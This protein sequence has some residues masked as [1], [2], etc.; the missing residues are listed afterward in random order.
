M[1]GKIIRVI[2]TVCRTCL[3]IYTLLSFS[4]CIRDGSEECP[5]VDQSLKVSFT[6][7]KDT[8]VYSGIH[9]NEI[10]KATLYIYDEA[11]NYITEWS[12]DN[13]VFNKEYE[14]G[15]TLDPGIYN[16]VVWFNPEAPYQI[17]SVTIPPEEEGKTCRSESKVMLI[18]PGDGYIRDI[19]PP[20]LYG[21][22]LNTE[23]KATADN[24]LI[25]PM[26]LNNNIIN[27]TVNGLPMNDHTY[28]FIISDN[29]GC[30]N[31]DNDFVTYDYFNYVA[32]MQF[33]AFTKTVTSDT[34]NTSL[35]VL[36]LARG[37][38]VQIKLW[39]QTTDQQLYP[40]YDGQTDN[41]I[42]LILKANPDNDFEQTN[43]YDITLDFNS[44]MTV[45][46]TINGWRIKESDNEIY[47][48]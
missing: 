12:L 26:T 23:I 13:P 3:L 27:L 18:V 20:L 37:R 39:D 42:D 1:W 21:S 34:L 7:T 35:T 5:L 45:E 8:H 24:R 29:N 33:P 43:I 32:T 22:G 9:M 19:L 25:I 44:D 28:E 6:Y 4:S 11:D 38:N 15:L 17:L 47:P 16:L 46:I 41:L 36:K 14:T 31:F 10:K 30:Y 48:G 40:A 2:G